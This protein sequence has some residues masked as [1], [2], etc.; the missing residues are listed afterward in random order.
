MS[1][2][3]NIYND[4]SGRKYSITEMARKIANLLKRY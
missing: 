1:Y 2:S 4:G 3:C